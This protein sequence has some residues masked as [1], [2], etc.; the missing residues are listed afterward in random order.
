MDTSGF[1]TGNHRTDNAI[2]II[3]GNSLDFLGWT[4]TMNGEDYAFGAIGSGIADYAYDGTNFELEY[5]WSTAD[6][7]ELVGALLVSEYYLYLSGTVSSVPVP[8]AVW[9]FGSGLIGLVGMARPKK[10]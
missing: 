9:L 7:G 5:S 2:N 3:D 4:T 1:I 10:A 6:S 8:A